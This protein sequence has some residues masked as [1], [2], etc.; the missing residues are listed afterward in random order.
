MSYDPYTASRLHREAGEGTE[1]EFTIDKRINAL[2]KELQEIIIIPKKCELGYDKEKKDIKI[3]C[4]VK[5]LYEDVDE[6]VS[7]ITTT[8]KSVENAW[9]E[10]RLQDDFANL[11]ETLVTISE[12]T[13]LM[14]QDLADVLETILRKRLYQNE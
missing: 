10:L 9:E 7:D 14:A 13:T 1:E 11:R 3:I 6:I 8:L 2:I 4:D 12:N 5:S